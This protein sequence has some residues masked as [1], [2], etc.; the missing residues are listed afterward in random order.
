M[1][2]RHGFIWTREDKAYT[3]QIIQDMQAQDLTTVS[4]RNGPQRIKQISQLQTQADQA[5][6]P[7]QDLRAKIANSKNQVQAIRRPESDEEIVK[8]V[9]RASRL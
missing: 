4:D 7:I 5:A 3:G 8:I 6:Q 1:I 9:Y 2:S